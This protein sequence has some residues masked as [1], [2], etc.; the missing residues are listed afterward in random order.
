MGQPHSVLLG[1]GGSVLLG[2]GGH[3]LTD[4]Q[5]L[6]FS[7]GVAEVLPNASALQ[8]GRGGGH[9]IN[10]IN[11]N[12]LINICPPPPSPFSRPHTQ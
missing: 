3:T 9:I 4:R 1:G 2:G 10:I 12:E 8:E 6:Q 11:I 5:L 7:E